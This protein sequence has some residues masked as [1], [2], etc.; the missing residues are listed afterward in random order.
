MNRW[1]CDFVLGTSSCV[2]VCGF[3]YVG[4]LFSCCLMWFLVVYVVACV[5]WIGIE[6]C[7]FVC[8]SLWC[9]CCLLFC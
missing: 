9:L 8:Y 7:Y 1:P 4:F 3:G 5:C 2:R 6:V